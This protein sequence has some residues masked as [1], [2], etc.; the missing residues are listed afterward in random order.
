M[1]I[2]EKRTLNDK[3]NRLR[4][5]YPSVYIMGNLL[6]L[7][8]T[9]KCWLSPLH[10]VVDP[11]GDLFICCYYRHRI[12]DHRIGNIFEKNLHDIWYSFEHY[13][14][15]RKIKKELCE[16]YDCRFIRYNEIMEG[17]LEKGQLDFI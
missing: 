4:A 16:L 2:D 1:N 15:I 11:N 13:S 6:P 8:A 3:L 14:K 5:K 12:K 17:A 7:Q 10:V 9:V